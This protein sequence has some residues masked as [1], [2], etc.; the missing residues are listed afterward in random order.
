MTEKQAVSR[1][2]KAFLPS[3]GLYIVGIIAAVWARDHLASS[4]SYFYFWT[5]N[6]PGFSQSIYYLLALIPII[7]IFMM[8][9]VQW[10]LIHE[11]DEFLRMIQIKG[12][13]FGLVCLLAIATGWGL[14]EML[15]ATPKLPI[16]WLVPIFWICNT[17]AI[18][19]IK[20]RERGVAFEK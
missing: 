13:L 11:L 15:A 3:L 17:V 2:H 7:A 16:F 19:Y 9:W 10:R 4:E 14:M 8:A 5:V 18:G 1:F 12:L 6:N 20:A